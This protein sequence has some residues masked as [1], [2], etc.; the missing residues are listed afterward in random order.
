M[1]L[2][3]S[4]RSRGLPCVSREAV[5]P[6]FRLAVFGAHLNLCATGETPSPIG[7]MIL[8]M[9]MLSLGDD[10]RSGNSSICRR[11]AEVD[12]LALAHL[13]L[14]AVA[15]TLDLLPSGAVDM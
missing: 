10:A 3:A 2:S 7:S 8:D 14:D 4:I 6:Y 12:G 15:E 11:F 13:L 1:A 9:I 5:A